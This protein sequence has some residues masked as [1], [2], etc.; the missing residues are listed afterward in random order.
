MSGRSAVR[1]AA[2]ILSMTLCAV[3]A[4]R[5]V[6]AGGGRGGHGGGSGSASHSAGGGGHG[7]RGVPG[8]GDSGRGAHHSY[9]WHG[10]RGWQSSG[11]WH[12][13]VVWHGGYYGRSWCWGLG[14]Y[15]PLLPWY[16]ATFWSDGM[17]YYSVDNLYYVWDDD[18][19]AYQAIA[20]PADLSPTAPQDAVAS[21]SEPAVSPELYAYPRAGQSE[22]QQQQDKAECRH[23]AE[24]QT[25]FDPSG[26][27]P[28]P[29]TTL[30]AYLR[31]DAACLQARY[32]SVR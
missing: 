30:Q 12:V 4:A 2:F 1:F 21:D 8:I 7:A 32:Y 20:P 22:A 3:S 6:S 13:S 9:V 19:G 24:S 11:R 27:I 14:I 17:P 23:W 31:A 5:G 29:W 25:G 15:L 10:A 16:Y 26:T 28:T 18:A